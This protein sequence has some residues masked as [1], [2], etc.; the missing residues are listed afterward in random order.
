MSDK[1]GEVDPRAPID[2]LK[3][4]AAEMPSKVAHTPGVVPLPTSD[5]DVP[6]VPMQSIIHQEVDGKQQVGN[7]LNVAKPCLLCRNFK[8]PKTEEEIAER[9][10]YVA[11]AKSDG[12]LGA[13]VIETI[14]GKCNHPDV[15]MFV[16]FTGYSCEHWLVTSQH[17]F[18][19]YMEKVRNMVR[20]LGG[21]VQN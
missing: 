4:Q 1:V 5:K 7:I 14:F 12:L 3:G 2:E 21:K 11:K 20:R 8:W 17:A 9:M 6:V 19:R 10:G 16:P 13:R 18:R 15:L